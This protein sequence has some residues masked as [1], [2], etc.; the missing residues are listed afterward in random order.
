MWNA[1]NAYTVLL[2]DWENDQSDNVCAL[3][4]RLDSTR[5]AECGLARG[6]S[7]AHVELVD[8]GMSELGHRARVGARLVVALRS[9]AGRRRR[10]LWLLRAVVLLHYVVRA[11]HLLHIA[12]PS[13]VF[14]T[15]W[16]V[17]TPAWANALRQWTLA[18]PTCSLFTLLTP[19]SG[20]WWRGRRRSR[21]R[22]SART[23]RFARDSACKASPPA[24]T[25]T[26]SSRR[27]TGLRAQRR[28]QYTQAPSYLQHFVVCAACATSQRS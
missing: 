22:R 16:L 18:G 25:C 11:C 23:C 20:R 21:H 3:S 13:R 6:E 7:D 1:T 4:D 14:A 17:K 9:V 19:G 8:I 12:P 27:S 2:I 15:D 10:L 5:A 26:R 24:G 28:T